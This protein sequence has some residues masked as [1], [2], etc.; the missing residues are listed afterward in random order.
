VL[1]AVVIAPLKKIDNFHDRIAALDMK[2]KDV[3][4]GLIKTVDRFLE[5]IRAQAP[6]DDRTFKPQ[7]KIERKDFWIRTANILHTLLSDT[8][9]DLKLFVMKTKNKSET[10]ALEYLRDQ[11]QGSVADALGWIAHRMLLA[12]QVTEE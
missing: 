4:T 7:T 9:D 11:E 2:A 5:A 6:K 1:Q 12:G 10:D 3:D 8:E